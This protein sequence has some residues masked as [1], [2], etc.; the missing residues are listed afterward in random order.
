[1]LKGKSTGN[2]SLERPRG[3]W[4]EN[5]RMDLIQI[6]ADARNWIDLA[7]ESFQIT[8][9]LGIEPLGFI[10]HGVIYV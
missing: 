4:V 10:S 1:M 6:A 7:L 5:V 2:I 8:W 9:E 3:R